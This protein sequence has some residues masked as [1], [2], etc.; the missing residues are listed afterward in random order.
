MKITKRNGG[1]EAEKHTLINSALHSTITQ[2][3]IKINET[4]VNEQSDAQVYSAY[5][6]TLLNFADQAK[7]SYFTNALYY[8]DTA[9]HIDEV[10]NSAHLNGSLNKKR[11]TFTSERAEVGSVGV[12]LCDLFNIDKILLD[13]L[14]IKIKIDL[15][16]NDFVP[17]SG[18]AAK[19]CKGQKALPA[20]Y[21]LT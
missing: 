20:I 2:F 16:G 13:G 1:L 14:E 6:K 21:T 3:T 5:I 15:N 10:V 4:F 18:K 11:D 7:I 9:G 19:N 12:T 8:Q 17:I